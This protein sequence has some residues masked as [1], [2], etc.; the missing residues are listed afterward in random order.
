MLIPAGTFSMGTQEGTQIDGQDVPP[1]ETPQHTVTI[2]K[3]FYFKATEVTR[4]EWVAVMGTQPWLDENGDPKPNVHG[5]ETAD[6]DDYPATYIS[7]TQAV[8]YCAAL[9]ARFGGP[10]FRLPTEAEWEYA[11]RQGE[12]GKNLLFAPV[13]TEENLGDYAWYTKNSEHIT[14]PLEKSPHPVG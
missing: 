6:K 11:C 7:H 3:A 4:G 8:A 9:N 5:V 1:D 13:V 10:W 2:T 12:L 14:A